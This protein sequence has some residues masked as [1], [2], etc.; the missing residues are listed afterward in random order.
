MYTEYFV[1]V[2][3]QHFGVF[4]I[5]A[6]DYPE[7]FRRNMNCV[8]CMRANEIEGY[9]LKT[10][11]RNNLIKSQFKMFIGFGRVYSR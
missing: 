8:K 7:V 9:L 3:E 6:K 10:V 11:G 5:E 4:A 2:T 1:L